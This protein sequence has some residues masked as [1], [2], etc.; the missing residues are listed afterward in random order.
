MRSRSASPHRGAIVIFS[1]TAL[2]PPSSASRGLA[3]SSAAAIIGLPAIVALAAIAAVEAARKLR[4]ETS[5]VGSTFV[6][7]PLVV[8]RTRSVVGI[9]R[10]MV[11]GSARAV[12]QGLCVD[13]ASADDGAC[14]LESCNSGV[15][16]AVDHSSAASTDS[17]FTRP[18]L[19]DF[20]DDLTR[21]S[22][23]RVVI[24]LAT[25]FVWIGLY[26]WFASWEWWVPAVGCLVCLS[27]VTYGSISHD[28]VH[29]NLGLPRRVNDFLLTWIE[30]LALRSGHA[31][32]LAHLHHHA[33][34]PREDDV[35]GAA[36]RMSLVRCLLEG[37]IFQ[38]KIWWW[39]VTHCH[40]ERGLIIAE[41]FGVVALIIFSAVACF[42][43]PVFLVYVVLMIMGSW[44]IP[45]VTSYIPHD[46]HSDTELR[47]TR[48]FRGRVASIVAFEHLYHL[49]HHLYPAVPH[50][51]WPELARRL[52]PYFDR[53]GVRAIRLL[54]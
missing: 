54:F 18:A 23:F 48:L 9:A 53:A 28:L 33:L 10:G 50:H 15:E 22:R 52:D 47:Q 49:E 13:G 11:K 19:L 24:S 25:P 42:W 43:T 26:F 6:F 16:M 2:G 29:S 45:L 36:A 8:E 3:E 31:Y 4:R 7:S 30:L 20:A 32:R 51:H 44:I 12:L 37:V 34:Y 21:V 40:R 17:G 5:F 14:V 38:P 1:A 39:A 41:G 46:P 35:E 27:F